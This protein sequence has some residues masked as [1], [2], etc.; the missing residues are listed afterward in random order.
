MHTTTA[1]M[2]VAIRYAY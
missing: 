1:E 2:H